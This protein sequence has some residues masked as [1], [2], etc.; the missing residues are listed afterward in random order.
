[1]SDEFERLNEV[2]EKFIEALTARIQR[3]SRP[4]SMYKSVPNTYDIQEERGKEEVVY[5]PYL[6]MTPQEK[7]EGTKGYKNI[8]TKEK[9]RL[10]NKPKESIKSEPNEW[11]QKKEEEIRTSPIKLEDINDDETD[12]KS[13]REMLVGDDSSDEKVN[14]FL[15]ERSLE[16][17]VL[18]P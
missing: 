3:S 2:T 15:S 9:M 18:Q 11:N 5:I 12:N 16:K 13:D 10:K 7:N 8:N 14:S 17:E 6:T 4:R 1:M